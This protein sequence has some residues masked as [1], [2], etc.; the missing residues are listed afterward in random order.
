MRKT[1]PNIKKA[2]AIKIVQTLTIGGVEVDKEVQTY[3]PYA[4]GFDMEDL[5][6]ILYSLDQGHGATYAVD[7]LPELAQYAKPITTDEEFLK[8]MFEKYWANIKSE[9][10]ERHRE[11]LSLPA[12]T[13]EKKVAEM[14]KFALLLRYPIYLNN[15]IRHIVY[16]THKNCSKEIIQAH[17]YWL[18]K[19][20]MRKGGISEME[21][22]FKKTPGYIRDMVDSFV[23]NAITPTE[24]PTD[25][26][27]KVK[28]SLFQR[29]SKQE[30]AAYVDI[31]KVKK[32]YAKIKG[33]YQYLYGRS[34]ET[35]AFSLSEVGWLAKWMEFGR[36]TSANKIYSVLCGLEGRLGKGGARDVY[37]KYYLNFEKTQNTQFRI[38]NKGLSQKQ[39]RA[40]KLSMY[41]KPGERLQFLIHDSLYAY[42]NIYSTP[43]RYALVYH[44]IKNIVG[45][46]ER[47]KDFKK[48]VD[49]T[50]ENIKQI[51]DSC[52]KK[53]KKD[54]K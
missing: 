23:A 51:V 32:V 6:L 1:R 18:L 13:K 27:I 4:G 34:S 28:T 40:G 44:Y 54:G 11:L 21:S 30:A 38:D 12:E 9:I 42:Y 53:R 19:Y 48:S 31:I 16:S 37:A 29:A 36:N 43:L 47:L 17:S 22:D 10:N 50:P 26:K 52:F 33:K 15:K 35:S 8:Q 41:K 25:S 39:L 7:R 3:A 14:K 46:I 2:T 24:T 49:S 20:E 45:G 5:A